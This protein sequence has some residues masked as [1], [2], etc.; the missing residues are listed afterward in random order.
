MPVTIET[1]AYTLD[2]LSGRAKEKARDWYRLHDHDSIE[3]EFMF[4]DFVRMGNILGIEF[5]THAVKLHGGGVRHEPNIY[6]SGFCSQGDGACF[7]GTWKL[8][9]ESIEEIKVE[10]PEDTTLH[11]IA[12]RLWP[13]RFGAEDLLWASV[14]HTKR[15]YHENSVDIEV[16]EGDDDYIYDDSA[17]DKAATDQIVEAL[18]DFCRWMYNQLDEENDYLN[19]DECVDGNIEANEYLFDED[20]GFVQ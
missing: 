17:I 16:G 3:T 5:D 11:D 4:E 8:R 15:Y 20:G 12:V 7:E 14:K 10:A 6:Y 18:R 13:M 1:K 2:E 9:R 19:S